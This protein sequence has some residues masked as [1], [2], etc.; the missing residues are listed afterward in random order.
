MGLITLPQELLA[1][2]FSLDDG[3]SRRDLKSL[4]LTCRQLSTE[5]SRILFY[6]IRVS[7]LLQDFQHFF[8]FSRSLLACLVRVLV[9][10]ELAFDSID[11]RSHPLQIQRNPELYAEDACLQFPLRMP[12][13]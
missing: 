8:E 1:E 4:R 2:V 10:E 12:E 3:L 5:A 13:T 7:P 11:F 6:Q 9:W